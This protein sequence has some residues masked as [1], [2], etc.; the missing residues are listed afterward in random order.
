MTERVEAGTRVQI[1]FELLAA[2]ERADTV[3]EDT[4]ST[5]YTVRVRGILVENASAGGEARIRTPT[6]R[7]L[8]GV[9]EEVQP[10]DTHSFGAPQPALVEAQEAIG[11]LLGDLHG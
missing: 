5:P 9:L 3:P 2:G 4:A 11:R 1:R 7:I 8:T 6:G 10:A